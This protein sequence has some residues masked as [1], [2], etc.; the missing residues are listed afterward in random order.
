MLLMGLMGSSR[1]V[2][3]LEMQSVANIPYVMNG[4]VGSVYV[5]FQIHSNSLD[6]NERCVVLVF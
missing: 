1:K 2:S 3:C 4:V 6:Y 5:R